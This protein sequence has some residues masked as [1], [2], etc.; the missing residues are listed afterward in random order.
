MESVTEF[1]D[2]HAQLIEW[3]KFHRKAIE[4]IGAGINLDGKWFIKFRRLQP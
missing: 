4:F 1:F 3:L 2:T